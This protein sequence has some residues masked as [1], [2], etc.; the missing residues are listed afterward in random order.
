MRQQD[1]RMAAGG[2][3]P[4]PAR[5]GGRRVDH[6]REKIWSQFTGSLLTL[7]DAAVDVAKTG[8]DYRWHRQAGNKKMHLLGPPA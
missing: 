4:K 8:A 1:V 5:R 2:P 3:Q 7:P 6:R